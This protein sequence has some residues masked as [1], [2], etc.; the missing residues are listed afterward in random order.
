M[1]KITSSGSLWGNAHDVIVQ[2]WF[3]KMNG[4]PSLSN[5]GSKN[6]H[7]GQHHLDTPKIAYIIILE[8]FEQDMEMDDSLILFS[9]VGVKRQLEWPQHENCR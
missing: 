3:V 5:F 9:G 4:F 1:S 2:C 8:R 7:T 6:A